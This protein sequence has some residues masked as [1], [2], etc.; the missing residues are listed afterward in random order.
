MRHHRRR[1]VFHRGEPGVEFFGER[2]MQGGGKVRRAVG[3]EFPDRRRLLEDVFV[4]DG[5]NRLIDERHAAGDHLESDNGQRVLVRTSVDVLSLG[6]FGTHVKRRAD[7]LPR[8]RKL[9]RRLHRLRDAEVGQHRP[10]VV[11]EHDVAGLD[12]AVHH[13]S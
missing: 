1:E 7:D 4:D 10:P 9:G 5:V 2:L 3:T 6:L 8:G 13:M 12:V 11:I